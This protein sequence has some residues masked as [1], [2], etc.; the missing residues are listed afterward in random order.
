MPKKQTFDGRTVDDAGE[1]VLFKEFFPANY[2]F[3][4]GYT[5]YEH[6]TAQWKMEEYRKQFTY[7]KNNSI[8]KKRVLLQVQDLIY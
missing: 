5:F 3:D 1:G 2:D 8:N 6:D 4:N 7:A